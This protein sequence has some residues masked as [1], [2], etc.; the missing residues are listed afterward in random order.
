MKLAQWGSGICG[1]SLVALHCDLGVD[2]RSCSVVWGAV[3]GLGEGRHSFS[4][5]ELFDITLFVE[6]R[7][8]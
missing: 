1:S 6:E 8:V 3:H 4:R 7:M 2:S 5:C